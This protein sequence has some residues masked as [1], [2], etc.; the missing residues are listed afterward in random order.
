M[1]MYIHTNSYMRINVVVFVDI[2]LVEFH[3]WCRLVGNLGLNLP[4]QN[5]LA[6]HHYEGKKSTPF[7]ASLV[8]VIMGPFGTVSEL[9]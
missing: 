7:R 8:D 9:C 1:Y 2:C 5:L 3:I 4:D 6:A